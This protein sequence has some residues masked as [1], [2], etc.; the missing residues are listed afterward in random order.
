MIQS[1]ALRLFISTLDRPSPRRNV[2]TCSENKLH[3]T[4]EGQEVVTTSVGCL[5][6]SVRDT[7]SAVDVGRNLAWVNRGAEEGRT[8]VDGGSIQV[9]TGR[10]EGQFVWWEGVVDVQ[11]NSEAS[12]G[13]CLH[14]LLGWRT[15]RDSATVLG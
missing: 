5:L 9:S 11:R 3:V 1:M 6:T 7:T 2:T 15:R 8:E 14:D 12:R 13:W 4:R 10:I